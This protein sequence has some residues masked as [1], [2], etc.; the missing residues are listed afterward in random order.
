MPQLFV[1]TGATKWDDPKGHPWT[2]GLAATTKRRPHLCG[3]HPEEK[4][5]AKIGVLYQNDDF[6]KDYLKGWSTG[7][8]TRRR[9]WSRS[10]LPTRRPIR[11]WTRRWST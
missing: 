1:T 7:S 2:I 10:R 11:P 8:A 5:D 6:G 9:R 3:L 4:P